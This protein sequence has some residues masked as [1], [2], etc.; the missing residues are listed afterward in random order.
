M[1]SKALSVALLSILL[2]GCSIPL[3]VDLYNLDN[4]NII[5]IQQSKDENKILIKSKEVKTIK[6]LI[7]SNPQILIDNNKL[8]FN[9]DDFS[10]DHIV[11]TGF[12]PFTKR[13]L[14]LGYY[15]GCLY[16][17]SSK[18]NI[19]ITNLK[20]IQPSGYPVCQTNK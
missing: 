7:D 3:Y 1:N 13:K 8:Q 10:E 6:H 4:S 19:D 17:I 18:K 9:P 12:G 5:V 11:F 2:S 15:D 20:E 16:L 14:T